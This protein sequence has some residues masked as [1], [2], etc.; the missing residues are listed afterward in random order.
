MLLKRYLYLLAGFVVWFALY[1]SLKPLADW[2]VRTVAGLEAG[3][4]LTESIRFFIYEVPKVL[5]LL[6]PS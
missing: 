4:H 6:V 2:L 5:M 1:F 3:K